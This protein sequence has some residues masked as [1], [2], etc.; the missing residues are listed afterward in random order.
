[1]LTARAG[2]RRH[3]GFPVHV[4]DAID[5]THQKCLHR[6][7][8]FGNDD[9]AVWPR[10]QRAHADCLGQ[11]DYRQ[12]LPTQVDHATDKRVALWHQGQ[13]GQLQHFLHLEHVDREQLAPGQPEHQDFQAVL[14]HQ[15]RSLVYRV[16]NAS[17]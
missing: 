10:L 14:T 17:H 2:R 9:G 3:D 13:F 6:T 11:V 15:L 7:V 5:P 8:V 16:E 12:G 4:D 1:M